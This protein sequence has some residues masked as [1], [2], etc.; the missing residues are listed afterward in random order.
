LADC[1]Q[2]LSG[3]EPAPACVRGLDAGPR[4]HD[5]QPPD[6]SLRTSSEGLVAPITGGDSGIGHAVA[7]LYAREG[8]EVAITALP[9]ERRDADETRQ[10]VEQE[11]RRCSLPRPRTR[12]PTWL[13][14][15]ANRRLPLLVAKC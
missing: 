13:R 1:L 7:V 8:A 9:A 2:M 12:R 5:T 4:G 15:L 10:A 6:T 3:G 11:G 14:R